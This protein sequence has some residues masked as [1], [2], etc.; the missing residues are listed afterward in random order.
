MW[1]VVFLS[2]VATV[3]TIYV[4]EVEADRQQLINLSTTQ[5][6]VLSLMAYREAAI[7]YLNANPSATGSVS[8]AGLA[9][10]FPHGYVNPGHWNNTISAG[11]LYVYTSKKIDTNLLR[12]K[13]YRSLMVGR[14]Q[15]GLL[16]SLSGQATSITI[17]AV[18]PSN[19]IVIVGS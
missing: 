2:M 12:E 7:K 19:A 5:T 9:P 13:F 15:S 17:P 18:V 4:L 6:D 10:Y 8:D 14:K 11:R 16:V 3:T 1:P